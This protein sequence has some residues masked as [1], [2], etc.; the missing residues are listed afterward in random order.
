MLVTVLVLAIVWTEF[1]SQNVTARLRRRFAVT[2]R[3]AAVGV[4]T[5]LLGK[6]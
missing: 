5:S 2:R 1:V 6:K 3:A 4:Q